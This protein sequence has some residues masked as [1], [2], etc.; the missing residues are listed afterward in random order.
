MCKVFLFRYDHI[1]DYQRTSFSCFN[2]EL[3]L[4]LSFVCCVVDPKRPTSW[5]KMNR[6]NHCLLKHINNFWIPGYLKKQFEDWTNKQNEEKKKQEKIKQIIQFDLKWFIEKELFDF[7]KCTECQ[8]IT[9]PCY[10]IQ[11]N[12]IFICGKCKESDK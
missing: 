5:Q 11:E 7:C 2:F 3:F 9:V 6:K 8:K 10:V 12:H 1:I 4:N